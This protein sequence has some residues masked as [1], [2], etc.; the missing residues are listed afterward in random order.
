LCASFGAFKAHGA[1]LRD[2]ILPL[3][4]A[5]RIYV[6]AKS[7]NVQHRVL[8][9]NRWDCRSIWWNC[10][11]LRSWDIA[12]IGAGRGSKSCGPRDTGLL[13]RASQHFATM[14]GLSESGSRFTAKSPSFSNNS[15]RTRHT[16][17][18]IY[19][20]TLQST[21]KRSSKAETRCCSR[22]EIVPPYLHNNLED[23]WLT[24]R[25]VSMGLDEK[26]MGFHA[27][28]RFRKTWLRGRRCQEDISNY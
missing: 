16:A 11:C 24:V 9:T 1:A 22:P 8:R 23:R 25:L 5:V 10:R 18:L 26:G 17:T 4:E 12:R 6:H 3:Q 28:R 2:G 27:F 20:L 15:R 19:I 14:D 7:G 13:H 21:C